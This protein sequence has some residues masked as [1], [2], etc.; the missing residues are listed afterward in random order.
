MGPTEVE[1][2]IGMTGQLPQ[3]SHYYASIK[4]S[5]IREAKR[6]ERFDLIFPKDKWPNIQA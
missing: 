3:Q 2:I 4:G 6:Q 1:C 5:R